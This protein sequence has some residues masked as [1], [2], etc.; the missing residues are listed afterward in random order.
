MESLIKKIDYH[1]QIQL[2]L[3]LLFILLF[4]YKYVYI[5]R[6]N[7]QAFLGLFLFIALFL[8]FLKFI[9]LKELNLK[10]T[11]LNLTLILFILVMSISFFKSENL[12]VGLKDFFNFLAYII[13]FF[14]IIDS[15]SDKKQ[16]NSFIQLYFYTAFFISLYTLLQY[17]DF[18][19]F[20]KDFNKITST[21]GQ[22]NWVSNYI[23]FTF[24]LVLPYL[25]L[26]SKEKKIKRIY[27]YILINL[28]YIN[29]IIC[30]SRGIWISIFLS[31]IIGFYFLYIY[32]LFRILKENRRMLFFLIISFFVITIIYS[33]HNPLNRS[34]D[35]T[36][37]RAITL[38]DK[39]D[40]SINARLLIWKNTL[41]MIQNNFWFGTGIGTFKLNYQLYQ[42]NYLQKY[43]EDIKYWIKAGEAHNEYL[44]FW[45][46]LGIIGL[47]LYI[48]IIYFYYKSVINYLKKERSKSEQLTIISMLISTTCFLIHC[49]FC[50]PL[51]VPALGVAFF[52]MIGLVIRIILGFDF[53]KNRQSSRFII[54]LNF[55][56]SKIINIMIILV[57]LFFI[58]FFINN[59]VI[60]P[61]FAEIFYY[62]GMI[63]NLNYDFKNSFPILK[64][65]VEL[66]EHNGRI[67]HALG[68]TYYNLNRYEEAIELLNQAIKYEIDKNTFYLLG[69]CYFNKSL[70]NQAE[71]EFKKAIYLYPLF[72]EAYYDL[73][74]LYFIQERYDDT[75]EQWTKILEIEPNFPN[76]YILLNNL[77]IVYQKKEMQNKALEYFLEALKLAPEDSPIIEE[78]EKEI[79][80]IYKS[81]LENS[82]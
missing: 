29:I 56:N 52:I 81:K 54:K 45:A 75:I 19:P 58:I 44:Q 69:L 48:L 70:Y 82:R 15:I 65:A 27:Y 10:E 26:S 30:Q 62:K 35:T 50:F 71:E 33:T 21:L 78:I 20:F 17:Y 39:D 73:G 24:F 36:I 13:L 72:D 18:D 7:Q 64:K 1:I 53:E 8:W 23:A 79:Y 74:Y 4:F 2:K 76:K 14:L 47:G 55:K 37:H 34:V 31:I 38:F 63:F 3:L 43:P 60:K 46:E 5:N 67:L 28:L 22:K 49:L 12:F 66:D 6:I 59:I 40:P 68:A 11:P 41:A 77:G 51:H 25:I 57:L 80:N 32:R 61:Y 42:A 9:I 16:I